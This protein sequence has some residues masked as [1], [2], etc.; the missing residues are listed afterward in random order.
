MKRIRIKIN[1]TKKKKNPNPSCPPFFQH[2]KN[3][4]TGSLK[5]IKLVNV[6]IMNRIIVNAYAFIQVPLICLIKRMT[7]SVMSVSG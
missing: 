6:V 5:C 2:F 1:M 4:F 7:M 3:F